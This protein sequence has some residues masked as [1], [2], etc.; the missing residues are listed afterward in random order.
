MVEGEYYG[1]IIDC[2]FKEGIDVKGGK[3][4]AN[5]YNFFVELS[6]ANKDNTYTYTSNGEEKTTDGSVYAG[7]RIKAYGVWRFL[8]PGDGDTFE[9]NADSN[10]YYAMFCES[11]G[12]TLSTEKVKFGDKEVEVKVL[13]KLD[14]KDINGKPVVAVIGKGKPWTNKEGKEVK[15]NIVRFVKK[16]EGG[17]AVEGKE[18]D[19]NDIPF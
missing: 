15:S 13:P 16:W 6:E 12:I 8:E 9:S 5:V 10:K 2:Q 1:H 3:Y 11:I 14:T 4:R 19:L 18:A 17:E 7:K